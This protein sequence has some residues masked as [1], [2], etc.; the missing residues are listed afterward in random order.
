MGMN[1]PITRV[2]MLASLGAYAFIYIPGVVLLTLDIHYP[3][4]E[5]VSSLLLTLAG[6]SAT[7]WAVVNYGWRGLRFAALVLLLS[8]L[9]EYL[10]VRTG[11]I[12]GP[13]QYTNILSPLL[14]D[15]VPLAI[16]FAWVTVVL[17]AWRVVNEQGGPPP[18]PTA[19]SATHIAGEQGVIYHAPTKQ[20]KTQ[21]SKLKIVF[22]GLLIMLLDLLIE[23]VAVYVTKF[24][25]WQQ[26]GV[27]YGI[28]AQNFAAWLGVGM[29]M[30]LLAAQLGGNG[31]GRTAMRPYDS[32]ETV[33]YAFLPPLLY[34]MNALLFG[35]VAVAHG[36]IVTGLFAVVGLGLGLRG[37][38]RSLAHRPPH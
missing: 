20:L 2:L 19:V 4:S 25:Y 37:L 9:V 11:R 13:Y 22:A 14:A 32:D 10:G 21:N 17:A 27:Y 23:P 30:A 31:K 12:F 35:A 15:T 3:N 29:V 28:P 33:G 26:G 1:N 36:Y 24:W 18:T 8:F 38:A 5:W 16:P 6:I 34:L 7:M